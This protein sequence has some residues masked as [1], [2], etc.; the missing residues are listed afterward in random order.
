MKKKRD[1]NA[2]KQHEV[3][4]R[5]LWK[6]WILSFIAMGILS[7]IYNLYSLCANGEIPVK[8]LSPHQIVTWLIVFIYLFPLLWMVRYHA[9]CSKMKSL[10]TFSNFLIVFIGLWLIAGLVAMI[11]AFVR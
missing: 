7:I 5:L 4:A 8:M 10:L 2:I 9:L 6:I 1:K 3:K 11:H